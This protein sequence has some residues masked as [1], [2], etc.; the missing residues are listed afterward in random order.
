MNEAID[1]EEKVEPLGLLD[2]AIPLATHWKAMIALPLIAAAVAVGITFIVKPTFT[3]RTTLIPPQQQGGA[4]SALSSLTALAP[5]AAGSLRTQADQY[6]ALLVSNAVTD[7][8]ISAFDLRQVY[9][10]ELLFDTRQRLLRSVQVIVGK[11]DGLISIDVDDSSPDRAAA[12]AN[13]FVDELRALTARLALTDAQQRRQFFEGQ[14]T[15]TREHLAKAQ[16]ALQTSGFSAGALR[17]EP[18]AAAE[19]YAKLKADISAIEIRLQAMRSTLADN[20]PEVQATQATLST[21]RS[22][23]SRAES[24]ADVSSGQDYVGKY[25]EFKYQEVLFD[26]LSRQ[27]ELARLDETKEGASVQVVDPATPPERRSRPH[28]GASA[29]NAFLGTL[30]LLI[31]V[32]ETRFLWRRT[33]NHPMSA[34]KAK[35][36][37][38][39]FSGVRK[40]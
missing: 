33:S 20:T 29:I 15:Q 5:L 38:S 6:A 18:R 25:R 39:A 3:A 12:I 28:R 11:K 21:L 37:Q 34:H 14:L 2:L 19:S 40:S 35:E 36:L 10:Q 13:R 22:Q 1:Q 17:S 7:K 27:Y 31:V 24:S 16:S 8:V 30:A 32:L 9:Q 4:A 23:L 26:I